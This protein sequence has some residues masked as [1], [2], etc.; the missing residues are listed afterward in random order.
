MATYVLVGGAWIGSW[1]WRA[2]T[3]RLR[4]EGHAVYPLSLTGLADRVHLGGPETNLDTHIADVTNLICFEEL[5]DVVLV[6]HSYA[7]AVITGVADRL[8]D[9]L[10]QVVFVDTAPFADGMSMLDL[11]SPEGVEQLRRE[12]ATCGEGWKLPFPSMEELSETADIS[13]LTDEHLE[14]MRRKAVPHPFGTWEQPLRLT[15]GG[16]A[17][18]S[19]ERVMIACNEFKSLLAMN[20]PQLAFIKPPEWRVETIETGHWPML[21]TPEELVRVLM[22]G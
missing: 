16:W 5:E 12:V 17:H 2:V 1:A 11:N 13:G 15:H 20:L 19:Y 8:P 18:G 22:N 9:R 3:D 10:S 4:A 14:L 7:G 21:S 6:G